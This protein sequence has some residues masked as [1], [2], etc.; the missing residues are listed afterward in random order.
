MAPMT[1]IQGLL[2]S[3]RARLAAGWQ[4]VGTSRLAPLLRPIPAGISLLFVCALIHLPTLDQ[5]L[6]ETQSFRQTHTAYNA[7]IFYRDGIDLL[8]PK[9][10]VFG[11]PFVFPIEFPIFQALASLVMSLGVAPDVAVRFT[12]LVCF[13]AT[14]ALL[15]RLLA[16]LA[17]EAAGLAGLAAFLFSPLGLLV[18]RMSLIEY[19]VTA[20]SL[21]FVVWSLNW[22]ERGGRTWYVAAAGA[23]A[24][25][26]L[27]KPTTAF[28]YF[29]PVLALGWS[30]WR[31]SRVSAVGSLRYGLALGLLLGL[32]VLV[33]AAWTVYADGV[34]ASDEW[35]AWFTAA[36]GLSDYYFGSLAQKL[37]PSTWFQLIEEAE[38]LLFGGAIW[39]WALLGAVA[40]YAVRRRAFALALVLSGALGPLIFTNQYLVPGQ[41]YYMAAVS[42]FVAIVIGLGLG[43]LWRMREQSISRVAIASL[44]VGWVVALHLTQGYWGRQYAGV[45]DLDRLLPAADFVAANSRPDELVVL[46]GQDW[47]PAVLY[48]ARR[49]GFMVRGSLSSSD[50]ARL[51]GLGFQTIFFCPSGRGLPSPCDHSPLPE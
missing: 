32:P 41:E 19:L 51:R 34:R 48:Y 12:A 7:L 11:P 3:G 20:A 17:G 31:E 6:L 49:E 22:H 29:V 23:G 13:L 44:A 1:A 43:W 15:W 14:G 46:A 45:H 18:S 33:G 8:H 10:P 39:L 40:A 26:M 35:T 37:D 25:A 2:R 47:N 36:G 16:R 30:S 42:P 24:I 5:P 28:M 9:L 38:G 50:V 27:V 4:A 21:A